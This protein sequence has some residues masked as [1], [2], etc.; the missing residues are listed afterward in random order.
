MKGINPFY[1]GGLQIHF[2]QNCPLNKT[3]YY[4]VLYRLHKNRYEY[5][6]QEPL[7]RKEDLLRTRGTVKACVLTGDSSCPGLVAASFY[8][9]KPVYFV[10]NACE[11]VEWKKKERKKAMAS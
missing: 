3:G 5:I 6:K 11:K 1:N 4:Y 7:T 8:D 10:S 2:V 9:S